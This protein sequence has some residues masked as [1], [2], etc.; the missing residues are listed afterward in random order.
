MPYDKNDQGLTAYPDDIPADC[1]ELLLYANKIK[2]LPPSIGDLKALTVLNVFNNQIGL[3]LPVEIG[4]LGELTEVNLAANRLAMLKDAHFASWSKVTVLNIND[5]N[6]T[7]LGS[8]APLVALQE[9]RIFGNQLTALPALSNHPDL[10]IY[11]VHK[12]RVTE[13]P[14]T[15][16][17]ATPALERLSIWSNDLS[18]LPSSLTQCANLVG[19]QAHQNP[20]LASLP[21]G[22]WPVSL[23]TLFLQETKLAAL[24]KSMMDCKKLLRVNIT[25]LTID[26]DLA[27]AMEEMVIAKSGSIFWDKTG[28]QTR[29]P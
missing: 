19:V 12:N 9:V 16:F 25:G 17:S 13:V 27:K 4:T 1:D 23:E 10:K 20:N 21:E 6:L 28:K 3:S 18:T 7:A 22:P 11:E 14:D 8:F 24:P 5:N 26:D 29:T 15:Y 2:K